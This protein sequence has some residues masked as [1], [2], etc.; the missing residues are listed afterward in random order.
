MIGITNS[1]SISGGSADMT[2]APIAAY[3]GH[4]STNTAWITPSNNLRTAYDSDYFSYADGVF[5]ATAS[6]D[7]VITPIMNQMYNQSSGSSNTGTFRVLKNGSSIGTGSRTAPN[8]ATGFSDITTSLVPG[9]TLQFQ[10]HGS[11]SAY[12]TG[13]MFI[14]LAS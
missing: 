4:G 14:R 13:G 2:T 10:C 9:D 11:T 8:S 3:H 5:T 7:V 1:A 12:I 6:C